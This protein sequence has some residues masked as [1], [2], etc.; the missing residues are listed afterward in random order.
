MSRAQTHQPGPDVCGCMADN[1]MLQTP[2]LQA[3]P[4]AS[5]AALL[6]WCY[7]EVASLS[8][9]AMALCMAKVEIDGDEINAIF[10]HRL[11]PLQAMLQHAINQ[12]AAADDAK[13]GR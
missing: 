10:R 7:G 5:P 11:E 12:L 6:G 13:A 2:A 8:A 1:W 4:A 3:N 9:T